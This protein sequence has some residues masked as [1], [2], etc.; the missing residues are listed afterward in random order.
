MISDIEKWIWLDKEKYPCFQNS[1]FSA[2]AENKTG[3][4]TVAEFL[5]KYQYEKNIKNVNI[6]FSAV[7]RFSF[8]VTERS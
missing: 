4:Y 6:R 8:T 2:M 1:S 7:P 3:E 5:K